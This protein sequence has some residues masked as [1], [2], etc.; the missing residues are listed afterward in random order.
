MG[1]RMGHSDGHHPRTNSRGDQVRLL[2]P[3]LYTHQLS[4]ALGYMPSLARTSG[5]RVGLQLLSL[6]SL[7]LVSTLSIQMR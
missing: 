3:A 6:R 1:N 7:G 2:A 5:S 4:G